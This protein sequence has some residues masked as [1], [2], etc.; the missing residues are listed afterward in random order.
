MFKNYADKA[1]RVIVVISD[2]QNPKI[3]VNNQDI[4][5]F[6]NQLEGAIE[7]IGAISD[8]RN[9][10]HQESLMRFVSKI[11]NDLYDPKRYDKRT[12]TSIENHLNK[13]DK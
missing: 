8:T 1:D 4:D 2:P 13:L 10:M 7:S 12:A 5:Q 6:D 11:Q 3:G 9:D